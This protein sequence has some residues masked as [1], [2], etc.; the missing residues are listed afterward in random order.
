MTTQ[1]WT[2]YSDLDVQRKIRE[3]DIDLEVVTVDSMDNE[4]CV[5]ISDE[6]IPSEAFFKLVELMKKEYSAELKRIEP[7]WKCVRLVFS[8]E[9][10]EAISL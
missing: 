10:K 6:I 2:I 5:E 4:V 7:I 3:F 8:P 9:D 1:D